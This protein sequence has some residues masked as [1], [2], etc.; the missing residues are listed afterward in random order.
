MLYN[1]PKSKPQESYRWIKHATLHNPDA[2]RGGRL[3]GPVSA[4]K[5]VC[6]GFIPV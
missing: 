2:Q 6:L 5:Q 4:A 1:T 3:V